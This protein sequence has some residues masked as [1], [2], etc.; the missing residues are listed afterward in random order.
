MKQN[1]VMVRK[2]GVFDV[3][4][5]TKDN[6]FNATS[7]LKQWN[8]ANGSKKELKDYFDNKSTQEYLE[9]IKNDN[10]IIGGIVPM[11][12]SRASKGDNAGTWMHPYLFIDFAMW[13][14]PK[15]KFEVIKFVYD[16]LIKIRND[17]GD[18]Y[19]L[20]SASVKKLDVQKY[21]EIATALQ[22]IVYRTTGKNLRQKASVK[23]L[24]ELTKL[25]VNFSW[26]IDMGYITT[27]AQLMKELAKEYQ[28]K[29]R[30]TPF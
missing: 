20:L 27:H 30:N 23:E 22:W 28:N 4:Q 10:S 12:K 25:Q 2:M 8:N 29:Y 7:L 9:V 17:A 11:V 24:E 6:M 14:N 1:V 19:V 26:A 15:F 18:K 3:N 16:E 5:R 21:Q 13:I